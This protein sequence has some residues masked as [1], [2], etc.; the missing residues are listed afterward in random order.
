MYNLEFAEVRG[1]VEKSMTSALADKMHRMGVLH[2]T[3]KK[4]GQ[5]YNEVYEF[6]GSIGV[7]DKN[8]T[9]TYVETLE[10]ARRKAIYETKQKVMAIILREYIGPD[11]IKQGIIYDISQIS[12]K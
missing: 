2:Y 8:T 3:L 9:K 7:V 4:T 5:P 12:D 11:Y 1:H 6:S 10:E